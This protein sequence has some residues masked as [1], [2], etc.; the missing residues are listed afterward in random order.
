[1]KM[2]ELIKSAQNKTL[3]VQDINLVIAD[4]AMKV[5][6]HDK[7]ISI[8]KEQQTRTSRDVTDIKEE[9]TLLPAE[10]LELSNEVKRK[11]T[12]VM[13]GKNSNAYKNRDIRSRIYRDI[14]C[15]VKRQ[16]GLVDDMGRQKSYKCLKRKQLKGAIAIVHEYILPISLQNEVDAENELD[17]DD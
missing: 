13:G 3:T 11:G 5:E 7:A 8:I 10:A 17:L 15:E 4:L 9:I 12:A 16:Y 1:M 14:Y 2:N 6:G